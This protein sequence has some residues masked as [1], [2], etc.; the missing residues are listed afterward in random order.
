MIDNLLNQIGN[1]EE[2]LSEAQGI[3]L[4]EAREKIKNASFSEYCRLTEANIDLNPPKWVV[5]QGKNVT[6][7][8][9]RMNAN[10]ELE[11]NHNNSAVRLKVSNVDRTNKMV[12]FN[13]N[14]SGI[15]QLPFDEINW[16]ALTPAQQAMLNKNDPSGTSGLGGLKDKFNKTLGLGARKYQQGKRIAQEDN[17]LSRLKQLAGIEESDPE[18]ELDVTETASCGATGAGAIATGPSIVGN[19]AHK[20]T[21]RLRSRMRLKKSKKNGKK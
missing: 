14:P 16:D 3:S 8:P 1:T 13:N 5:K 20:P 7:D 19:T 11:I 12:N 2:A 15:R 21:D 4:D 18:P 10:D 6:I 9:S 17:E